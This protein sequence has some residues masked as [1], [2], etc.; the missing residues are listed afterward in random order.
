VEP[1]YDVFISY[2]WADRAAVE[3]LAQA[4]RDQGLR[5]FVDD[6]EI[7]DFTR[8]T[9]TI[10]DSLAASQVL[11]AYYSVPIRPGGPANGS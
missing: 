8:I 1:N 3:P 2:S 6:P 5:M 10:T 9:A 11:L 7:E 4:L